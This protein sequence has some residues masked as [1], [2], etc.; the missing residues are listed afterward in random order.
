MKQIIYYTTIDGKCPYQDWYKKLD[1]SIR[2]QVD[3][4]I[5]RLEEGIYGD[6]KRLSND[7]FELR[8]KIGSGYR[9]Y[10]TESQDVIILILCTGDKSSQSKD[11]EKAKAII[12]EIKE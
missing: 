3:R 2:Q 7:L 9:I 12:K 10:F 6:C 11:I 8:F 4:R 5:D 1:K